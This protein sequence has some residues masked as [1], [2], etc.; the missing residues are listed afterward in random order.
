MPRPY[1]G[2]VA[3]P[4]PGRAGMPRTGWT[5]G[6]LAWVLGVSALALQLTSGV[7]L[8]LG[9]L[10]FVV[11]DATVALVY[12]TV[13]G[14]I[15]VRRPHVVGWLV[16][17]AAIGG[18]VAALGG[19]WRSYASTHPGLPPLTPLADAYGWAW[20]PGTVGLF[21]L[22]PWFV[23][24]GRLGAGAWCGVAGGVASITFFFLAPSD[25]PRPAI[26][27]VVVMGLVTAG[28]TAWR[29]FRGPVEER[30][31]L[32]LLALGTALMA[33][34]FLPLLG[35]W[36]DPDVL[37][38]LPLTHLACQALF[39]AAILVCVLRNRLWGIDLVLSRATVAAMLAVGLAVVYA[40]VVVL[41]TTV[42]DGPAAQVVAAVG[43]ALAVQ[44]LHTW[45]RHR[46]RTLVYGEGNDPGRAALSVGRHLSSASTADDLVVSLAVGVREA[47]RLESVTIERSAPGPTASASPAG[48]APWAGPD[49]H[50]SGDAVTLPVEH[51]GR[52]LGRVHVVARAGERL[53]ARTRDALEQLLPVLG[54]GLALARGARELEEARDATTRARLAE[55]RVIRRE[56]HDGVG[57]W[58]VGLRLG[59]QGAR[60][61]LR[62]DPEAAAAVLD[63]LG[64]EVAQRVE[65]VRALSRS[66]LPPSLDEHGLEVALGE[67]AGRQALGGFVVDVRCDPCGGLDPRVAAAAYAIASESVVNAARHSGAPEC[68]LTVR[69]GD[70]A[71]VV[72]CEDDGRGVA[73]DAVAGVGSRSLRERADELGGRLEVAAVR[74]DGERPG[75][76][77]RATLPLVPVGA[78][79]RGA[80][81]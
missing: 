28:A 4:G 46:V 9:D 76:R 69:L 15:L 42:V 20:V 25:D 39:P 30:R 78:L 3:E 14:V 23:R 11:V 55:R 64:V 47:L 56:L 61:T 43:V 67:L 5:I 24:G 31:G 21:V 53:D 73:P 29:R 41:A 52:A 32:G 63:A 77:V 26:V 17:L 44:P 8:L 36:A 40:V 51:G 45:L 50:P 6:V 35:T 80:A 13:A 27:G 81:S 12:G 19:G 74:P 71:L 68:R 75:T 58:L 65:D 48:P 66:L 18:G 60:N 49:G 38:A 16:A 34:S 1:R 57:P 10:L 2:P 79:A 37:L 70:G 54:A 22:V 59:L 7:P 33:L 62:T 72:T